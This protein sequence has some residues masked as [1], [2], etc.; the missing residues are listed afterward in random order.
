MVEVLSWPA[1]VIVT[2]NMAHTPPTITMHTTEKDNFSHSFNF[3]GFISETNCKQYFDRYASI[4]TCGMLLLKIFKQ[5]LGSIPGQKDVSNT[6][7]R[8]VGCPCWCKCF[9]VSPTKVSL[10]GSY[11]CDALLIFYYI[12]NPAM[13]GIGNTCIP[14]TMEQNTGFGIL[15]RHSNTLATSQ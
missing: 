9:M 4:L 1:Y 13:K 11:E 2:V 5:V 12:Y 6:C 14:N 3:D 8:R 7:F 15:K 10:M